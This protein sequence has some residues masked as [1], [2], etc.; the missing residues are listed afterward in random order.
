MYVYSIMYILKHENSIHHNCVLV[1]HICTLH[2]TS[3]SP[4]LGATNNPK[5][6]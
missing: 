4:V 1:K 3:S 2:T 6:A 5:T